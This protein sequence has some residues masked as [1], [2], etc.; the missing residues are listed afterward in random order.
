MA[1]AWFESLNAAICYIQHNVTIAAT[2]AVWLSFVFELGPQCISGYF[3]EYFLSL[4]TVGSRR[5]TKQLLF[6]FD[7]LAANL[8]IDERYNAFI[9]DCCCLPEFLALRYRLVSA[10]HSDIVINVYIIIAQQEYKV[11]SLV[12]ILSS[13][14]YILSLRYGK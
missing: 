1:H 13:S 5:G 2:S 9:F 7:A 4:F 8:S 11:H 14:I 6:L 10:V 12:T 3:H